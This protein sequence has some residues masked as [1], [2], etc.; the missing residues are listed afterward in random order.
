MSDDLRELLCQA[1][2]REL[3]ASMFPLIRRWSDPPT[4]IQVLE[5]LDHCINGSLASG[6]VVRFLQVTYDIALGREGVT[7]EEIVR[8]ATW[9]ERVGPAG[10]G[11][12]AD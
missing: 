9:H 8:L 3:D 1:S 12:S 2:D 6:F 7:H 11:D 4:A 5:V 10:V